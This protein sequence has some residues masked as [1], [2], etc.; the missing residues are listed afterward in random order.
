MSKR[1][2]VLV[3]CFLLLSFRIPAQIT[4]PSTATVGTPVAFTTTAPGS[5]FTW[6]Y[7][8]VNINQVFT[9]TLTTTTLTNNIGNSILAMAYD[10]GN[11]RWYIFST[12]SPAANNT[13]TWAD[14]GSDPHGANPVLTNYSVGATTTP[15]FNR[16][17]AA[18][19]DDVSGTWHVFVAGALQLWR[20][21]FGNSLANTPAAPVKV[22]DLPATGTRSNMQLTVKK[23]NTTWYAFI[24][25]DGGINGITRISLGTSLASGTPAVVTP[26]LAVAGLQMLDYFALYKEA[27][28]WYVLSPDMRGTL[29]RF[30]LGTTLGGT[31]VSTSLGNPGNFMGTANPYSNPRG[32]F[33]ISDCNQLAA[34]TFNTNNNFG[35]IKYDFNGSILNTPVASFTA[36]PMVAG[37]NCVN[38]YVYQDTLFALINRGNAANSL[39]RVP[40]LPFPSGTT[41][42][43]YDPASTHTFTAPGTYNVTLY[44]DQAQ[45]GGASSFCHQVVVSVGTLPQPDSF[46]DSSTSVCQGQQ[47]VTYAVPPVSGATGYQWTYSGT[48]HTINGTGNTVTIDFSGAATSGMLSVSALN[49]SGSG[50]ARNLNIT[51]HQPPPVTITPSGTVDICQGSGITLSIPATPGATYEWKHDNTLLSTSVSTH[52]ATAA[53]SYKVI[54]ITPAGCTDSSDVVD[55]TVNTVPDA[56]ITPAGSHTICQGDTLHM[57]AVSGSIPNHSYQW[58]NSGTAVGNNDTYSAVSGGNYRLIVMDNSTGCADTSVTTV[59]TVSPLPSASI[60]PSGTVDICQ[61]DS[62]VLHAG[63]GTGLS[64]EW[65]NGTAV[66]G[67]H[68]TYTVTVSGDYKV[69]VTDGNH[70]TGSSA[71]TT[72]TVHSLPSFSIVPGD[73]A[74]CIGEKVTLSVPADTGLSY[75]WKDM[76]GTIAAAVYSFLDITTSGDYKVVISRKHL[77]NCTDSTDPVTVTVHPLP[78]P[79]IVWDGELLTTDSVYAAYQWYIN[80]Q[81]IAGATTYTWR[82]VQNAPYSLTVTDSNGC[83]NA[84]PAVHDVNNVGVDVLMYPGAGIRI[85]PNPT[86]SVIYI[87]AP[88]EVNLSVLNMEG[89]E[90]LRGKGVKTFDLNGVPDGMYLIRVTDTLGRLLKKE[91]LIKTGK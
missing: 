39:W 67:Y 50:Q 75:Q 30:H 51:V 42:K 85:Y 36:L 81:P 55:V 26:S 45:P 70:C 63:G 76:N 83:S 71:V 37:G 47:N 89:R 54:V 22:M 31:P 87:D 40:V 64:Y 73:T 18:V 29:I 14:F 52:T 35:M 46:T 61:Q 28:E 13:V 56:T 32:C 78:L 72:V 86:S 33:I 17:I 59:L 43:F 19:K 20:L 6:V 3:F 53:G 88:G 84:S 1:M 9:P 57:E 21:D 2:Y 34:Y 44:V 80:G 12:N 27:G 15:N 58:Q 91:S 16:A 4:G 48:G 69:V 7:D 68:D 38:T 8:T 49:G 24:T 41:H 5:T 65:S 60:T 74:F 82:P 66:V 77:N 11:N 23:D 90:I 62:L 10:D 79:G 25:N